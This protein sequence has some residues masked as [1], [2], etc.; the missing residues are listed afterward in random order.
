MLHQCAR[1]LE[2]LTAEIRAVEESIRKRAATNTYALK[3]MSMPG[4]DA[5]TAML[6]A[7]EIDDV[8]RFER[9][10]N[11]VSWAGMCPTVSQSGDSLY[12]GRIKK[13]GNRTVKWVLIQAA[14]SASRTDERLGAYHAKALKRHG[15]NGA[16]AVTHVAN[17]MIHIM[18]YML[19][20]GK[21]YDQRNDGLYSR[22]IGR[23]TGG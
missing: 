19:Q 12:Y 16:V 18:W 4:V 7:S 22:K 8:R 3:L 1:Q 10:E 5:F 13:T 2:F 6:L 14:F 15:G 17:K 9:P 11:M 21:P 23:V 20:R